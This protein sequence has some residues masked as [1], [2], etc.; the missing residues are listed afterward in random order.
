MK[1]ELKK[2]VKSPLLVVVIA[3]IIVAGIG[4]SYALGEYLYNSDDVSYNNTNSGLQ[5]T[6][7]QGAVDELYQHATDYTNMDA[8]VT[9]IES[10][11][12]NSG[13]LISTYGG[14]GATTPGGARVNLS[15]G[16]W[17]NV[18][19]QCTW[20]SSLT[21]VRKR[22]YYRYGLYYIAATIESTN[23]TNNEVI[24]SITKVGMNDVPFY[25]MAVIDHGTGV[26]STSNFGY[27][28]LEAGSSNVRGF[29]A[30]END[31]Y[32]SFS[33]LVPVQES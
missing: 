9:A 32:F 4:T 22:A 17:Q 12:N 15:L 14:T 33:M 11:F 31:G 8:R 28:S 5:S 10:K 26:P 25:S 3:L 7:V 2:I 16:P 27:A 21:Y 29:K 24:V 30:V 23:F 1:E 18:T 19:D 6:N 13:A 20:N